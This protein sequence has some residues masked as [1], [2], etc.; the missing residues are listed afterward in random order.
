MESV[1][2]P[3]PINPDN[4]EPSFINLLM[5]TGAVLILFPMLILL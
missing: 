1:F 3:V 2:G 4:V 5:K